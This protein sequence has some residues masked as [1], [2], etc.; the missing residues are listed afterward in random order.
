MV[1]DTDLLAVT[2]DAPAK[3]H[4][5]IV[6]AVGVCE[7]ELSETRPL[8]KKQTVSFEK[9]IEAVGFG[10]RE[11][12]VLSSLASRLARLNTGSPKRITSLLNS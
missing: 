1:S 10:N 7:R 8:E 2:P 6:D 4:F 9:L 5:V 12:D 3:T 11:P